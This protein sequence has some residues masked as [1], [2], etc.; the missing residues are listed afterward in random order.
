MKR[1]FSGMLLLALTLATPVAAEQRFGAQLYTVR[2]AM[3]RDFEGTLRRVAEIGYDDIE[4]AGLFGRDPATVRL[5]LNTLELKAVASHADWRR[6]R[7]DPAGMFVE[8]R[9]LGATFVV[10]A[11]LPPEQR[12]TLDQWRWWISH[13][14]MVGKAARKRGL[15]LAYH[16]H[17][18]EYQPINGVRPIDLLE[19]GL[20]PKFV[21][22]EMDIYWTVKGGG[23][24]IAQL[25]KLPGRFPLAHIKDMSEVDTSM[26]DV[27][28]GRIDFAAIFS[29]ADRADFKHIFVE[30]DDSTDPFVTLERGLAHLQRLM[31]DK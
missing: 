3:E 10:L 21:D 16:A 20:D 17:D 31:T 7:D 15:R 24:P 11:W 18:F 14:N 25:R 5:L 8:T 6:L 26:A 12:Q 2:A 19:Q 22:F 1:V 9:A 28:D 29:A 13:L 23:D 27:G 30:R 4:L